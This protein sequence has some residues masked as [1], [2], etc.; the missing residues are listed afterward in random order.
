[1]LP[2]RISFRFFIFYV[3]PELQECIDRQEWICILVFGSIEN[4]L[5]AI[6]LISPNRQ[7]L[8]IQPVPLKDGLL[9]IIFLIYIGNLLNSSTVPW[10][11]SQ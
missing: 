11:L 10:V 7:D 6:D 1:M 4:F 3:L 2:R 8:A 5:F 9:S